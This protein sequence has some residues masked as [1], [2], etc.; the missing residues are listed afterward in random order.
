[1]HQCS[2]FLEQGSESGERNGVI[3]DEI[4]VLSS[5]HMIVTSLSFFNIYSFKMCSNIK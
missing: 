4:S 5:A 1:M 2:V 3:T